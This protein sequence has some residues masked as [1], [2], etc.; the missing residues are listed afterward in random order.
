MTRAPG[1]TLDIVMPDA[2]TSNS[3]RNRTWMHKRGERKRIEKEI[4]AYARQ[5]G[6]LPREP[7]E[8]ALVLVTRLS[9]LPLDGDNLFHGMKTVLDSLQAVGIIK[10]DNHL[11]IGM[12][13]PRWQMKKG[14]AAT[15]I[16]VVACGYGDLDTTAWNYEEYIE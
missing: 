4:W 11:C 16:Q 15:R 2:P 1:Y 7:L 3:A 9:S 14:R 8:H 13:T 6:P 5:Q 10:N 12:P